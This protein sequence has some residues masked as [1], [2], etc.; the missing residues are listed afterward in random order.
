MVVKT[1]L[2]ETLHKQIISFDFSEHKF[3]MKVTTA[4][5]QKLI[6]ML[7]DCNSQCKSCIMQMIIT[8]FFFQLGYK[9]VN[10]MGGF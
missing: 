5:Y 4:M 2:L 10:F 1:V 9:I 7:V 8:T 3:V 6:L